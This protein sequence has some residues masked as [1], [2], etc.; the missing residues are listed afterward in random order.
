MMTDELKAKLL[1]ELVEFEAFKAQK[2]LEDDTYNS[3]LSQ[4]LRIDTSKPNVDLEYARLR[5][6]LDVIKSLQTARERL[7][8][9]LRSRSNHS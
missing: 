5:G 8:E 1:K 9:N 6:S 4:L 7:I 3:L 2:S